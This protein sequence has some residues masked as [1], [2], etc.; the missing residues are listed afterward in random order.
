MAMSDER[1]AELP[2]EIVHLLKQNPQGPAWKLA[3]ELYD[4]AAELRAESQRQQEAIDAL[5]TERY[6]LAAIVEAD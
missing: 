1:W 4:Y 5:A 6:R 2:E 3:Q